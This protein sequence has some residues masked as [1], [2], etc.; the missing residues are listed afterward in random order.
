MDNNSESFLLGTLL[1]LSGGLMDA[2]SYLVRGKV[3]ANA[4]TG[5]ILFIGISLYEGNWDRLTHY[6]FPVT[7]FTLGIMLAEFMKTERLHPDHWKQRI[8]LAEALLLMLVSLI[9]TDLFAN[10]LTSFACG[11][12]VQTF[13]SLR[14]HPFATTMCIGN[15]RSATVHMVSWIRGHEKSQLK[16]SLSLF[17]IIVCFVAGAVLGNALIPWLHQYTILGCS[18][19]LAASFMILQIR[20]AKRT[21]QL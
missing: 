21:H 14:G 15:L 5:N 11:M 9:P 20:H 10:S 2:Y 6:L 4:Q 18:L 13:R 17:Y 1:T 19:L 12:Q 8:V 7:A 3:F 16:A